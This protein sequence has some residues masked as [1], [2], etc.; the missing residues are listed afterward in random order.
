MGMAGLALGCRAEHGG[1]VVEAL[2]I[3]L[4]GEIEVAAVGLA[5]AGKGRLEVLLGL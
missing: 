4:L 5:L 2:D 1:N 3:R